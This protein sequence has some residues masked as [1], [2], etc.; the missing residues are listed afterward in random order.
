LTGFDITVPLPKGE[1]YFIIE[2]KRIAYEVKKI[3]AFKA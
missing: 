2:P 1:P 3:M